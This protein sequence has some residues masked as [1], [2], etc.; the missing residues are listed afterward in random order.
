MGRT[1]QRKPRTSARTLPP[2]TGVPGIF[3]AVEALAPEFKAWL[4]PDGLEVDF[5]ELLTYITV[6]LTLD[7][8]LHPN[9]EATAFRA[10]RLE[11]AI[12][13]SI[14]K[15]C[16]GDEFFYLSFVNTLSL[17]TNFLE[18]TGR[19]TGTEED[20]DA[21]R[22]FYDRAHAGF[23]AA[24]PRGGFGVQKP[25]D[26]ER[27]AFLEG[28]PLSRMAGKLLDG[29]HHGLS[30]DP[31]LA[32]SDAVDAAVEAAGSDGSADPGC[33]LRVLQCLGI[34]RWL[35]GA[36]RVARARTALAAASDLDRELELEGW[37]YRAFERAFTE[38]GASWNKPDTPAA[39]LGRLLAH[40]AATT[41]SV[42]RLAI[43]NPACMVPAAKADETK[44][45]YAEVGRR[46]Q[47]LADLGL[48]DLGDSITVP[49]ALA[50]CL[51]A[52]WEEVVTES[53][54]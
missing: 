30:E 43:S 40:A 47:D 9:A 5:E 32:W 11:A 51:L 10:L 7:E 53:A 33:L 50:D 17:F 49:P 6:P 37:A 54:A 20:L 41:G 14:E 26:E 22:D 52:V 21:L 38:T 8:S 31:P 2:P 46:L 44:E 23:A 45:L 42:S 15:F 27:L 18:Q 39:A 34:S 12:C 4:G 25:N 3:S 13:L 16:H 24:G 19:W 36:A 28:L 35:P 29:I 1:K 48:V